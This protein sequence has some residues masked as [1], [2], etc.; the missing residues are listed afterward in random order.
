ML[1]HYVRG[2]PGKLATKPEFMRRMSR[3]ILFLFFAICFFMSE[4]SRP[5]KRLRSLTDIGSNR[6]GIADVPARNLLR[7]GRLI[8]RWRDTIVKLHRRLAGQKVK[9]PYP[10]LSGAIFFNSGWYRKY[11]Q[12]RSGGRFLNILG[13]HNL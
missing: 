2:V 5:E 10:T 9:S 12:S 13:S 11:S 4:A 7:L 8:G 3:A 6:G 1:E